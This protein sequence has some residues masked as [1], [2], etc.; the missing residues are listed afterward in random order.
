MKDTGK[1][2]DIFKESVEKYTGNR[3]KEKNLKIDWVH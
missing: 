3:G 1:N 2:V